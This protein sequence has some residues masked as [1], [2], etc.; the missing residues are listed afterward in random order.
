MFCLVYRKFAIH[1]HTPIIP[2]FKEEKKKSL[3]RWVR[4]VLDKITKLAHGRSVG[5]EGKSKNMLKESPVEIRSFYMNNPRCNIALSA[6][7]SYE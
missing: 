2:C 1:L 7:E 5:R 6:S 4:S 3:A